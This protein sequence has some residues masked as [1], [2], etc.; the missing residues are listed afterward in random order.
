MKLW[1]I[2]PAAALLLAGCAESRSTPAVNDAGSV[3][4]AA[5]RADDALRIAYARADPSPLQGMVG[6]RALALTSRQLAQ[7]AAAGVRREEDV[8]SRHPVHESVDGSHAEVVLEIRSRQRMVRAGAPP[9][10]FATV[11]RQWRASLTVESG[12][13]IVVDGSDLP[14][15]QWWPP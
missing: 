4:T 12:Q 7:M 3:T 6:G 9:P 14:P 13:W 10:S 11:L 1:L 8:E 2:A 15:A 5:E